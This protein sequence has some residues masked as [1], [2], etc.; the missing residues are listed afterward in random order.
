M[1]EV[2]LMPS[3]FNMMMHAMPDDGSQNS[4]LDPFQLGD[5]M[6]ID[7]DKIAS[8]LADA[9]EMMFDSPPT[10]ILLGTSGGFI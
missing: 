9:T 7:L 6:E 2:M 3:N 1:T 10:H 8:Y 4:L 5:D